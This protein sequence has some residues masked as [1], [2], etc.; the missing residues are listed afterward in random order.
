MIMME[1]KNQVAKAEKPALALGLELKPFGYPRRFHGSGCVYTVISPR[2]RGLSIGVNVNRDRYCN[3]DCVYCEVRGGKPSKASPCDVEATA[4]ELQR[5]LCLAHS[6]ELARMPCYEN[7]PSDLMQLREVTLSGDGEPTLCPNLSEVVSAVIRVRAV[8]QFP[9]FKIVLIT[10]S[11][12]LHLPET[13]AGLGMFTSQDEIWAK[14]DA[15]TQSW[16]DRINLPRLKLEDIVANIV[17]VG[18]QRPIVIQS[19]FPQV[20]NAPPPPEEISAY[21]ARLQEIKQAG[22]RISRVQVYSAH[23]PAASLDCD[24]LPL[25][26]LSHIARQVREA[27]GL[28]VDVF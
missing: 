25:R 8:S 11:S 9:F 10:N 15:G 20:Q 2:A 12:G 4:A 3:F 18:K 24:H 17:L 27:T 26:T 23:R 1:S 7:V 6:G 5:V 21:I 28:T 14:L 22:T 16:M 13:Q 19:L